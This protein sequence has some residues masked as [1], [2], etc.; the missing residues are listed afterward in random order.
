MVF[1]GVFDLPFLVSIGLSLLPPVSISD[2]P[3]EGIQLKKLG[4]YKVSGKTSEREKERVG[5]E[6]EVDGRRLVAEGRIW[7]FHLHSS[8]WSSSGFDRVGHPDPRTRSTSTVTI[9]GLVSSRLGLHRTAYISEMDLGADLRCDA[10]EHL[11]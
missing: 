4:F 7:C 2:P 6:L 1:R 3:K 8:C 10:A 5:L 9:R 11:D